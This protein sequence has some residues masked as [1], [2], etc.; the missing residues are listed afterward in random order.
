[1]FKIKMTKT[2]KPA[3]KKAAVKPATKTVAKK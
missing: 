1:M 2:S 3:A